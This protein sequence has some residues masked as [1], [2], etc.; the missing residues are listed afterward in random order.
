MRYLLLFSVTHSWIIW[1][2]VEIFRFLPIY[3]NM[4]PDLFWNFQFWLQ[5]TL[6]K[7]L[8]QKKRSLPHL[9]ALTFDYFG[10]KSPEVRFHRITLSYSYFEEFEFLRQFSKKQNMIKKNI[11]WTEMKSLLTKPSNVLPFYTSSQNSNLL[12]SEVDFLKHS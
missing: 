9:K 12:Y 6:K 1:I 10:D 11:S 5:I 4:K 8:S 3:I 7:I 2:H